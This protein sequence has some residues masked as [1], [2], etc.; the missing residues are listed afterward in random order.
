M[1]PFKDRVA[2]VE[3]LV[4]VDDYT[5]FTKLLSEHG[6]SA[7]IAVRYESGREL[8]ILLDTGESG[9]ILVENS[10]RLNVGLSSVDAIVLSHRHHDHTGG[11]HKVV[12]LLRGKP[13]IAHPRVMAPCY[14][15]SN[16]FKRFDAGLTPGTRRALSEFELVLTRAPLELAPEVWFLGE[17]ERHYNNEYAVRG[18][19]T[20]SEGQL[21]DEPMMDDTGIAVRVDNRAVV[22][23]GCSHSGAQ[24]IAKQARRVTKA[25][26]VVILGGLHLASAEREALKRVV[27][28]LAGEGVVE[29]HAGH[30]TGL[31]GEAEL[32]NRYGDKMHRIHSGYKLEIV[33]D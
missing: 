14:V 8:N 21:I 10:S 18:F 16:G 19:K 15:D 29:V 9:S 26:E 1:T 30:C 27:D 23:V 11:L 7:L 31:E 33:A 24:N 2:K 28:E 32:L 22:V 3:I 4:L 20:L 6:F 13:V 5:S 25:E 12:E 17:I